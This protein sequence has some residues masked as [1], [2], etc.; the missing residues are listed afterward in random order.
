MIYTVIIS[1]KCQCRKCGDIIE[2]IKN[3]SIIWC[4]CKSIYIDGGTQEL[5]RNDSEDIIELSETYTM[6][7]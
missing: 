5:Q 3:N 7:V 6:E 2:S 4:R 1:N